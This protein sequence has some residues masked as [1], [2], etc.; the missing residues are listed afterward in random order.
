M[1]VIS[2]AACNIGN[3]RENNEDNLYYNGAYLSEAERDIPVSQDKVCMDNLQLYA[4]CDGMG[5]EEQGEIASLIAVKVLS[6]YQKMLN[7]TNYHSLSKYMDMYFSEVNS[8]ICGVRKEYGH[9]R[10]GTT[11][12]LLAVEGGNIHIINIG[13]SRVYQFRHNK[14]K[15]LSEDHTPA[16]RAYQ[17]GTITKEEIKTHPHRN[18]LTQYLGLAPEEQNITPSRMQMK[19]KNNDRFLICS[20]GVTDM[21]SDSDISK[22]LKTSKTPKAAV[23][24]LVERAK[25][26]GGRDNITAIILDMKTEKKFLWF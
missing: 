11:I 14:L 24:I 12:A 16:A 2:A 13:D 20:D 4:V 6:K 21:L 5:G 9:C 23:K 25:A 1:K 22:I 10:I 26:N 7:E 15:Q 17:M 3:L 18:K 19:A 8:Q